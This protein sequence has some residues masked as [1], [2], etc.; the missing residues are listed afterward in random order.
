[1]S[2]VDKIQSDLVIQT[3][4]GKKYKPQW[5]NAIKEATF[6]IAEFEFPEVEGTL[7]KR[8]KIK[9]NKY[10]LEIYFQGPD[11]LSVTDDFENS[12]KDSRPW[13]ITHPLYGTINVQPTSLAYDNTKLN[14][15]KITGSITETILDEFPKGKESPVDKISNDSELCNEKFASKYATEVTPTASD[16]NTMKAYTNKFSSI[17]KQIIKGST[18]VNQYTNSLNSA[19]SAISSATS[20]P[21]LAMRS[22]QNII[23]APARFENN[24][25]ER[26]SILKTEFDSLRTVVDANA[27]KATKYFYHSAGASMLSAMAVTLST[28]QTGDFVTRNSINDY[29]INFTTV[30]NQYIA[31]LDTMQS[32][33]GGLQ[34]SFIPD[35]DSMYSLGSLVNYTLSNLFNIASGAKQERIVILQ[36]DSNWVLLAHRFYGFKADDSTIH[37]LIEQNNLGLDS[38]LI[39]RKNTPIKYYI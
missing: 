8:S 38:I 15:T 28:P 16:I 11:H 2:W 10:N 27:S 19:Y 5:M 37:D 6:N 24:V 1:M 31:D 7:V 17:S 12:S 9:G 4:D 14:V 13:K 29:V 18:Q 30:Y 39:V 35:F 36:T 20:A 32:V 3:G 26:F 21:L 33:N 22:I 25:K 23:K 34:S